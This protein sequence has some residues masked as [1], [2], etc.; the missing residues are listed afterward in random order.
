MTVPGTGHDSITRTVAGDA[1]VS[2]SRIPSVSSGEAGRGADDETVMKFHVPSAPAGYAVSQAHV[3]IRLDDSTRARLASASGGGAVSYQVRTGAGITSGE[4]T[5]ARGGKLSI[6]VTDAVRA[7]GADISVSLPAAIGKASTS[8][9]SRRPELVVKFTTK[10]S[11]KS[12]KPASAKPNTPGTAKPF[13]PLTDTSVRIGM[14]APSKQ[15]AARLAE[16]G[17]VDSRRIFGRLSSPTSALKLARAEVAAGRMPILSFKVPNNDW[18]GVAAGRYDTQLRSLTSDLAA[19]GGHAFVTLHHEP[20]GDGSAT[21]YAAMMRHA[22]PILG[23]PASVDAGPIVNGFWWSKGAQGLTDA[24][25]AQWLPAD[26][27]RVSET[28]AAD[29]YQGGTAAKPGEDAGVKIRG[30]SAWATRVGVK[31]LG[32]G[33]YNGLNAASI[34][35]AGDAILAD[36]RF[37]FAAIFNSDVNNRAGVSWTL[38]GDR[39][40][41]FK[42]TVL[43]ARRAG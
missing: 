37:S 24:Q 8:A 12:R 6:D 41:A 31:R 7:G 13:V 1:S 17:S 35:A 25:I 5:L 2:S 11:V 20:S 28:V 19:L 38:A 36:P 16:T 18:A 4:A 14:S 30:F 27:L 33:E 21:S 29:T 42:A 40:A 34:K 43:G 9:A 3:A 15:W 22:L 23:A 26:V 32:I 39:L 10:S